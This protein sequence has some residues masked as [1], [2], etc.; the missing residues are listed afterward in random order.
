MNG[1]ALFLFLLPAMPA[2]A[3]R[4][5]SLKGNDTYT[6]ELLLKRLRSEHMLSQFRF[7]TTSD[8]PLTSDY[9][10]FPRIIGEVINKY[11]MREFHLSLTQGFWRTAEWGIAPQ[12]ATPSGAQLYAWFDGNPDSVDERWIYLVNSLNGIFC[13]SLLQM[14]PSLS[15][16]PEFS[17]LPRG[18]AVSTDH[19]FMRYGAL[20]GEN[21]CT[22]NL[23]PWRKL[24]PCKQ[25]GLSMLL[26]PIKLYSSIFHS[27]SVHVIRVCK[28]GIPPC[29]ER[30]RVELNLNM[31]SDVNLR[32]RTLDWSL[33]E[34]FA[35]K[36][37]NKCVVA[38]SSVI[39]FERDRK[40]VSIDGSSKHYE[41][42]GRVFFVF[43]IGTIPSSSF[44]IN[45][46]ARYK[47]RLNLSIIR[48]QSLF[49]LQS[50]L[51]GSNQQSGRVISVIENQQSSERRAIYTHII[52]WFMR[53]YFHTIKYECNDYEGIS[54]PGIVH[55][56]NF[57]SA[58]D[59]QRPFLI[60]WDITVPANSFCEF[61]FEFDKAF[62]KVS[63]F[64]PD[65]NHGSYVPAA[66]LTFIADDE[67]WNRNRSAF[68]G[69]RTT[70]LEELL[71]DVPSRTLTIFGEAL[72]VLL[73]VPDFSMPFNVIC[74][75]CTAMAMLFGPVHSLTTRTMIPL[76]SRDKDLAPQPPMWRLISF[77]RSKTS[78]LLHKLRSS[79]INRE[80]NVDE[81]EEKMTSHHLNEH[82]ED[83]IVTGLGGSTSLADGSESRSDSE[84]ES[85]IDRKCSSEELRAR[86]A[87]IHRARRVE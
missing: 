80:E 38:D 4:V 24:L 43:D 47:S 51:G 66:M 60:E 6:E 77:I 85:E 7:V 75:V 64:P 35:R 82:E 34:L 1:L 48:P 53:V 5:V 16:S 13:T 54:Q 37:D 78:A 45:L 19:R 49:S 57:V 10:T 76:S 56:R 50:Y 44:P 12:P 31:V 86:R 68:G 67:L 15:S 29:D 3:R 70:A 26:N 41:H 42:D 84:K 23:T 8:V 21:V 63:E 30:V 81:S 65:A 18:L 22:E 14:V 2:C 25:T 52:P 62:L 83:I 79:S 39:I 73:P 11:D 61:S 28:N 58:K 69:Y 9:G 72:L 20:T 46:I 74:L 55:R 59:R 36:V 87:A 27:M 71:G 33:Y 40:S 32:Y 17:F